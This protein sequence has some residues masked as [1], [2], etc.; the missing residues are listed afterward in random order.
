MAELEGNYVQDLNKIIDDIDVFCDLQVAGVP[1][2]T[3]LLLGKPGGGKTQSIEALAKKSG[4]EFFSVHF[5]LMALEEFGGIPQFS[6]QIINS[7]NTITTVWSL[8]E[9]VSTLY[10][11]SDIARV[12]KNG[13]VFIKNKAD[14]SIRAAFTNEI[15]PEDKLEKENLLNK[16]KFDPSVEKIVSVEGDDKNHRV[17]VLLDDIHRCDQEHQTALLEMLSERKLKNYKFP[18][19]T[20]LILAGNFDSVAGARAFLSPVVNRCMYLFVK[21]NFDYWKTKFAIPNGIHGSIIAFL[22]S[23]QEFFHMEETNE[24]PW[25]SPRSWSNFSNVITELE[26]RNK[27]KGK[28]KNKQLSSSIINYYSFANV[29]KEAAN[30]FTAFFTIY[31]QFETE[32]IFKTV[33][34][35]EDFFKYLKKY[36]YTKQFGLCYAC[37]NY[38]IEHYNTKTKKNLCEVIKHIISAFNDENFGRPE[39]AIIIVKDIFTTLNSNP[40]FGKKSADEFMTETSKMDDSSDQ[41]I[42]LL[43]K[44]YG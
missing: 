28:G 10:L 3:P 42:D 5:A 8:P 30:K 44:I 1:I 40:R 13:G 6:R 19:E 26:K 11:K 29:G 33:K 23:Y 2:Q 31:N 4:D 35:K 39:I 32:E 7:K 9:F 17:L 14:D 20:A 15:F 34:S 38:F 25:G 21:T 24:E 18:A 37:I 41:L 27:E 16:I 43:E 12:R 36:D 22:S